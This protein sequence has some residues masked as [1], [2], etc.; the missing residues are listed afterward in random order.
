MK[1]LGSVIVATRRF[2]QVMIT[3]CLVK[4]L[5]N[6]QNIICKNKQIQ[7]ITRS[8]QQQT[9]HIYRHSYIKLSFLIICF[10]VGVMNCTNCGL[11]FFNLAENA[12]EAINKARAPR[13][14][15][16]SQW[17]LEPNKSNSQCYLQ[18]N[19]PITPCHLFFQ[20]QQVQRLCFC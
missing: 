17:R 15:V 20:Q 14:S 13:Q 11:G 5:V 3:R 9:Q 10:R 2:I 7:S 4:N 19:N 6:F 18:R 8:Q 1:I 16:P 12:N